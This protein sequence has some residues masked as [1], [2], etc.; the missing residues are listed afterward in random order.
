MAL[1]FRPPRDAMFEHKMFLV[2]RVGTHP[3]LLDE[4]QRHISHLHCQFVP[5]GSL[6]F[7]CRAGEPL[8]YVAHSTQSQLPNEWR[9]GAT[10]YLT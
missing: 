3:G 9:S 10:K 5:F 8:R 6:S 1:P 4:V 2:C 7:K